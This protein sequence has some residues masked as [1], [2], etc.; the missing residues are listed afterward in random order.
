MSASM[1]LRQILATVC[2]VAA[3]ADAAAT[4]IA[5]AVDLPDQLIS[6]LETRGLWAKYGI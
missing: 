1:W 4:L 3:A 6:A 5:N 2:L